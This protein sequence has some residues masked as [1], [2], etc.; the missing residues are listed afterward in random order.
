MLSKL[1]KWVELS[2]FFLSFLAGHVNAVGLLGF[3]HQSVSHLSGIATRLGFEITHWNILGMTH[4]VLILIS[5]I[6]GAVFSGYYIRSSALILEGRYGR[7]LVLEGVLLYGAMLALKQGSFVGHY[8]ASAACGLQNA[9]IS[10]YSGAVIRTT[11][12]TGV[13]TDLGIMIGARLRGKHYD[14]RRAGLYGLLLCGFILGGVSGSFLYEYIGFNS[15]LLPSGMAFALA[16]GYGM[17]L[18]NTKKAS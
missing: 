7:A 16:G 1:P 14:K 8:F 4:L 6:L 5:F 10:T 18:R 13:F 9:M 15:L 17:M 12:V 11:H 3:S 2:V